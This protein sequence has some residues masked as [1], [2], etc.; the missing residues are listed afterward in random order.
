TRM[1]YV[2]ILK[3]SILPAILYFFT[4]YLFVHILAVKRNMQGMSTEDLPV[5]RDTML[6][7]WYYLIPLAMLLY[8]LLA[9]YSPMRVGFYAILSIFFITGLYGLWSA[10]QRGQANGQL[11]TE[12]KLAAVAGVK[13]VWLGFEL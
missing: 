8:L 5:L 1:P 12:I 6:R 10:W 4:V 2:E 9:G 7:G 3:V 13:K 11:G